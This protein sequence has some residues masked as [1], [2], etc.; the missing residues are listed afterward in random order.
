MTSSYKDTDPAETNEWIESISDSLEH[1]GYERTRYLLESLIN[2]AQKNGAR[3]PFNTSTPYLNTI[4]PGQQPD[5]PGDL[6]IEMKIMA[7]VRWNA[8]SLVNKANKES[9]GIG[10]HISTFQSASTLYEVGFNHIFKGPDHPEGQDL[11]YIQGHSSPGIYSRAY[12]EGRFT[13]KQID[14]FRKELT[15]G[16]GLSSY[17]HPYLMP[18]F[19]QFATVSMGLGPIMAI[20]QARFMRYLIDRGLTDQKNRKVFAFLGDGEMDEPESLGALTLA[21]REKLD[22]LVFVVNCNLQ[23]LDGPVRGNSR[24]IQELEG[25]F[26]GAGWNVIKVIW[27]SEWDELIEKDSS[28]LLLKRF[29][30]LVDGDILKYTVEGGSYIR[31]HFFGKYP[32]LLQSVEHLSDKD[33]EEMRPGGHDPLKVFSAYNEALSSNGKPSVILARTVKGYGLGGTAEG[34]N[35]THQ[36]KKLEEDALIHFRDQLKLS[37]T[38]KE[39]KES[40]L[41]NFTKDS[42]E[43]KYLT[44]NRKERGGPVPARIDRSKKITVPDISIFDELIGGTGDRKISTTM[45]FIRLLTILTKDKLI[46]KNIVPIVPDEART[47]GMDPLFRQIGIYAHAGQLYEPVDSDQFLYYKEAKNGQILEEGINE[48][49]AISSFNAAGSSY[50]NHGVKMVPFYIFYSMFGFQRVWDFIWAGA[51]MRVRGFLLGGTAGRT[52]LNGEGLQHQDGHSHIAAAATPNI[53]AYDCAFSYEIATVVHHGLKEMCE[54]DKDIIYY[55]TLENENYVHPPCPKNIN[56][57]IIN[58]LYKLKSNKDAQLLLFGSGPLMGEVLK[59]YEILEK[60]WGV[61]SEVWSVTSF[62]EIRKEA[63]SVLRWNTNHPLQKSKKSFLEK[64]I[65]SEELPIVAVSDYIKM[66]PHQIS[67]YINN[68]YYVLGTD[69]FGRSDTRENLRKFFE[70]DRYYIVLS[71][72]KALADQSI[73]DKSKVADAIKKYNIDPEKPDP[74]IS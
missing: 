19:W 24:V 3:L 12:L 52:T 26:R 1:H 41:F 68:P 2:F 63:E 25:A 10:G 74:L 7:A 22:N 73:I 59:A 58:G 53:K 48:G 14:A 36:K 69:G 43:A 20:Y 17:P 55:L 35:I 28:G 45:S 57:G 13:E 64:S 9:D 72:L 54:Q 11:V 47:F 15:D 32:E 60:D 37:L 67:P 23:R 62:S 50:V 31:K 40:K 44:K 71:S 42:P 18:D 61:N 21:S 5:Y 39:V 51:D 34:R 70:I 49:G 46:G 16:G 4:L 38:D 29:E 27:G 56:D 66:I 8:M 65:T 6:E 30:E 33:L